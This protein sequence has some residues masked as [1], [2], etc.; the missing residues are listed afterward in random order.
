M[1]IGETRSN[2]ECSLRCRRLDSFSKSGCEMSERN[3][4]GDCYSLL[5]YCFFGWG[6][7]IILKRGSVRGAWYVLVFR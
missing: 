2:L 4:C 1:Q 6:A 7:M 3:D 5:V